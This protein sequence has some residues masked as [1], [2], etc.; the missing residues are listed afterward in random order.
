MCVC[1]CVC[2][3]VCMCV[4]VHMCVRACVRVNLP[5]SDVEPALIGAYITV[6]AIR[7]Q[8]GWEVLDFF[9][10]LAMHMHMYFWKFPDFFML[11]PS[12]GHCSTIAATVCLI[13]RWH[14]Y[15]HSAKS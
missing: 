3:C 7:H 14:N 9:V 1:V 11:L 5:M 8:Y 4:C 13:F 6:F 15:L 2:V 10:L 12:E